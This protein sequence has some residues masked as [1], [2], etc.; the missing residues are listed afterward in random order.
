MDDILNLIS[1]VCP[2][3]NN[4][5]A[6]Y[7]KFRKI[8]AL[9]ETPVKKHF[10]CPR[11]FSFVNGEK[12]GCTICNI[13]PN[14]KQPFFSKFRLSLKSRPFISAQDFTWNCD[15]TFNNA[16]KN[17]DYIQIFMMETYIE[18]CLLKTEYSLTQRIF[19]SCGIQMVC[20]FLDRLSTKF[21]LWY[22][23]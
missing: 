4:C 17:L 23:R 5:P 13:P 9:E 7:R 15:R 12:I 3:P 16:R 20:A 8:C 18:N 2:A 19:P 11:C 1:K 22:W 10:Y 6:S 21:G 14:L